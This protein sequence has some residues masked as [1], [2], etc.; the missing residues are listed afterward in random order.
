MPVK[1]EFRAV[2]V[3]TLYDEGGFEPRTLRMLHELIETYG[4]VAYT[5]MPPGW[6]VSCFDAGKPNAERWIARIEALREG[7]SVASE[8]G[9]GMSTGEVVIKMASEDRAASWPMGAP[10][11][12]SMDKAQADRKKRAAAT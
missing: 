1:A 12:G 5:Y 10:M 4:S 8:L 7:G 11:S 2:T 6:F 9:V 3:V